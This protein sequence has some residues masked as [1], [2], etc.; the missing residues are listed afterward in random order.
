MKKILITDI[1]GFVGGYFV[2]YLTSHYDTFEIHDISRSKPAWNFVNIPPEL[3]NGHHFHLADL[4]GIQK[5][6]SLV[7]EIQPDYVKGMNEYE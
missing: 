7:G 6:K 5:I 2:E 1:S 4:N 3:E